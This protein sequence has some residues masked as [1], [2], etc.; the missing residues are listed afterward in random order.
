MNPNEII[1]LGLRQ[2]VAAVSKANGRLLWETELPGGGFTG[3]VTLLADGARV[4][5]YT[6][7]TLSCLELA[8]G[9][10]LWTNGLSGY[11]FGLASLC[12]GAGGSSPDPAAI[13]QLESERR[14]SS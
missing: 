6:S 10:V 13:A 2:R 1:L 14:S 3:F 4:F 7:G 12:G 8:S 11:G 9:R 5:A